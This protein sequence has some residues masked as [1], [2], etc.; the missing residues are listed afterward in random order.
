[1]Q[2][3]RERLLDEDL[4]LR[5]KGED[6]AAF[7]ELVSRWQGRLWKHAARLTQDEDAAWDVVQDSWIAVMKGIQN[8]EVPAAFPAWAYKIVTRKCAD[9]VRKRQRWRKKEEKIANEMETV[10]G[11]PMGPL[12]Q[13]D[14][15]TVALRKL[16]GDRRAILA[17]HYVDGFSMD[18]I[19]SIL[20]IPPGTVKSRL[21][22]ARSQLKRIMEEKKHE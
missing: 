6:S 12:Q 19:A 2:N 1:M 4:V 21:F 14:S 8:L 17:L 13:T 20:E 3:A 11:N 10:S 16:P 9:W 18:E 22:H 5:C 15:L 7:E